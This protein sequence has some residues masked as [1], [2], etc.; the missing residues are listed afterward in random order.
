MSDL[1]PLPTFT[2]EWKFIFSLDHDAPEARLEDAVS[3]LDLLSS[4]HLQISD[5]LTKITLQSTLEQR[6][7]ALRSTY[8]SLRHALQI[9]S[10]EPV[11]FTAVFAQRC[12]LETPNRRQP[13]ALLS[14]MLPELDLE[15]SVLSD[16]DS[17]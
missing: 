1:G 14:G 10:A 9:C 13:L 8:F 12:G 11:E 5:G 4:E 17:L 3:R 16:I 7:E 6:D 15:F 2:P